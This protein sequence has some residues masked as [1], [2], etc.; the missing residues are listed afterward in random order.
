M[1]YHALGVNKS[2]VVV[3]LWFVWKW[4]QK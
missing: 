2:V 4:G 3:I 1:I